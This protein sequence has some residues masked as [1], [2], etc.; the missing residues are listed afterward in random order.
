MERFSLELEATEVALGQ[1]KASRA[2]RQAPHV[3]VHVH[4]HVHFHVHVHVT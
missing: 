2:A 4:V 1:S 3:H